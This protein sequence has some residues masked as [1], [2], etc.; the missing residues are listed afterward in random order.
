[1][2]GIA[3]FF[4]LVLVAAVLAAVSIG[5]YYFFRR[6]N[7]VLIPPRESYPSPSYNTGATWTQTQQIHRLPPPPPSHPQSSYRSPATYAHSQ[8]TPTLALPDDGHVVY[9]P[10]V[11]SPYARTPS[12]TQPSSTRTPLSSTRTK[13]PSTRPQPSPHVTSREP[14][15]CEPRFRTTPPVVWSNSHSNEPA[16]A[17]HHIA[18]KTPAPSDYD[19]GV[20]HSSVAS[21]RVRQ[22]QVSSN[23]TLR[24]PPCVRS[25]SEPTL[26]TVVQ[27]ISP[28]LHSDELASIEDV[29]FARK[30]REQ[31]RRR[32]REM[33][34]A[35][36]RAKSAQKKGYR[37]A[38][39]AHKQE[40]I[41]HKSAMEE[42]DKRAAKIIFREKNKVGCYMDIRRDLAKVVLD[43]YFP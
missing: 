40:A 42:L 19:S 23:R 20:Y 11:S 43:L 31:A 41:A 8:V 15:E 37:G 27:V 32:G 10:S 6:K 17:C 18:P 26:Q 28:D 2:R 29:E 21:P 14:S 35:R 33:T 9:P 36:G 3:V 34:D 24:V 30:L 39:Q 4:T 38:A 22:T 12:Q 1:M 5:T 16:S 13:P 25:G 7:N